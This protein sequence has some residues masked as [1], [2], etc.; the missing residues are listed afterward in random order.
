M[1]RI[2]AVQFQ[3]R[4]KLAGTI[5]Q[6]FGKAMGEKLRILMVKGMPLDVS[7][8]AAWI[9]AD[10][11]VHSLMELGCVI[12][13]YDFP[14]RRSLSGLFKGGL[15]LRKKV[16]D[17][18]A[19][20]VHVHF[21][22]AQAL[23]TVL[24]SPKP[25][26]ISFCG[27]DLLGN[28]DSFG[29]KTWSGCLSGWLSK[30]AA[31]GAKASIAKTDELKHMLWFTGCRNTCV[32]I[33]NGVNLDQFRPILQSDARM[34]LGWSL[35]DRVV[36]FMDRKGA[37]VKDPE[38][39]HL[40]CE[41]A[42]CSIPTL[43]M[44]VVE[45][46]PPHQMPLLFSAADVLLITSRHEGSNN[47]VKEALACNLPV[48]SCPVGDIPERLEHVSPSMVVPRNS[49]ALADAIVKIVSQGSRSN[50]REQILHLGLENIALRVMEVYYNVIEGNPENANRVV[51]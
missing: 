20:I 30:L 27:S 26:I 15:I 21:A 28:Y 51:R 3:G 19:D 1:F 12:E 32:V 18:R 22:A 40:V 29:N 6:E 24:F 8:P 39:A 23:M 31:L 48:V 41:K 5:I 7:N 17:F 4:D 42:K 13:S 43:R 2:V 49:V 46:V 11:Q 35:E 38:L 36:L 25:V 16:R 33:P 47:T 50:G 14:D 37:W 10:R 9:W 34:A 45:N 44:H